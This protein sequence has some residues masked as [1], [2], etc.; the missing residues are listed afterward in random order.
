MMRHTMMPGNL[1]LSNQEEQ[2]CHPYMKINGTLGQSPF[3]QPSWSPVS[4]RNAPVLEDYYIGEGASRYQWTTN[5][6]A[7]LMLGT[8]AWG[9]GWRFGL[10]PAIKHIQNNW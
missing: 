6:M 8:I 10:K 1:M 4:E 7:A 3:P 2:D 9:L 5:A